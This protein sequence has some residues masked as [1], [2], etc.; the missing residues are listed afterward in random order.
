LRR[1]YIVSRLDPQF[2]RNPEV[3]QLRALTYDELT[4]HGVSAE[5]ARI[6]I[7]P[8]SYDPSLSIFV[9]KTDWDYFVPSGASNI[10]PL[11]DENADAI[12]RWNRD[13]RTEFVKL[14][15]DDPEWRLIAVSEQGAMCELWRGWIEFKD[16]DE[17]CRRFAEAIGFR[18][19]EEALKLHDTDYDEFAA[20]AIQ[21]EG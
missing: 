3:M 14:Y 17:E 13:G 7:D 11:W 9:G 16:S 1:R 4:A 5:F 15:H 2:V 19:W 10:V 18:R 20:W 12:V 21:L 8:E 6:L